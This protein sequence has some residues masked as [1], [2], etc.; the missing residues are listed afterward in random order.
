MG[1]YMK[2]SILLVEDSKEIFRMVSQAVSGPLTE[3]DW[4]ETV[5]EAEKAIE[6]HSYDIMLLDIE[7]PDGNGL[8]LCS[9]IQSKN[10]EQPIFFLTSHSDLSE[11][12]LGFSA[13]A[14]DYITKPFN[15]LE[16]KARVEAKLKKIEVLKRSADFLRWKEIEINK[17]SQEVKVSND[18]SFEEIDLTALEFKLLTY[19][20]NR[21]GDV[22]ERDAM[23]N[24]IWGEDVH[25]YSRSVDTH[26]SKL[27]KKLGPVSH[28][29]ESVHGAG[30]KFSPTE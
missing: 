17:A 5:A 13:G 14:D 2:N 8:E 16:L 18:G 25:V 3:L 6:K 11:K 21:K 4:V 7:L 30:Y 20:A 23:L 28:I 29:I 9:K 22:I 1:A 12:V 15:P 10:P 27:R 24:D 26:V 19:F